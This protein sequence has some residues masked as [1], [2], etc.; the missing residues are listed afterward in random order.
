MRPKGGFNFIRQ[1]IGHIPRQV[2]SR[3]QVP[4]AVGTSDGLAA[5]TEKFLVGI[6]ILDV[7][8]CVDGWLTAALD[9]FSPAQRNWPNL[10]TIPPDLRRSK[11]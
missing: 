5:Q 10:E 2:S 3:L 6:E 9:E 4:L 7:N 1:L 8:A 11:S